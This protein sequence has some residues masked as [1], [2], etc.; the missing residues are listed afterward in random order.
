MI[1]RRI[2]CCCDCKRPLARDAS[3]YR[4]RCSPC[5]VA[6]VKA[7]AKRWRRKNKAHI[8]SYEHG[9]E[10]RQLNRERYRIFYRTHREA[11]LLAKR[12]GI[13]LAVARKKL[14]K[15]RAAASLKRA[16]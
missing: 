4:R 5:R 6:F 14:L 2:R 16:A 15:Q 3:P 8:R 1:F 13:G 10:R 7:N 11:L 12:E 9:E